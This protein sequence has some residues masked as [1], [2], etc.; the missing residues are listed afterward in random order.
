MD[1]DYVSNVIEIRT[2]GP[3]VVHA[4]DSSDKGCTEMKNERKSKKR[5]RD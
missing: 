3:I 4:A 1:V 5:T 2:R